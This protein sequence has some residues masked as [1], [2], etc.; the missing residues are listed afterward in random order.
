MKT[1]KSKK[2]SKIEID[3]LAGDLSH[4]LSDKTIWRPLDG[5]YETELKKK[6]KTLTLRLSEDLME[7]IRKSAKKQNIDIQKLVRK[8]LMEN[9]AKSACP[10]NA[11]Q[12]T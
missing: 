3:P 10:N 9:L 11:P 1:L 4:L 6:D 7:L 8:I 5:F 2:K 12:L